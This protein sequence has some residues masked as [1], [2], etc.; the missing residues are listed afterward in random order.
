M[1][2]VIN[3]KKLEP[4]WFENLNSN[5]DKILSSQN[6]DSGTLLLFVLVY[7]A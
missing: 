3:Y 2:K 4:K 5:T 1:S 7:I 6:K